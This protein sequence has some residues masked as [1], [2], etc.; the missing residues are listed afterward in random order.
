MSLSLLIDGA[1]RQKG[2]EVCGLGTYWVRELKEYSSSARSNPLTE[3]NSRLQRVEMELACQMEEGESLK[4]E[5]ARL[6][7]AAAKGKEEVA[8]LSD[9]GIKIPKPLV[10][11]L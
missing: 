7:Q 8:R 9:F 2:K 11:L 1:G 10:E 4:E 5:V 6:A 3:T